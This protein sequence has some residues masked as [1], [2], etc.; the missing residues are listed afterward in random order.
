MMPMGNVDIERALESLF[1]VADTPGF[2]KRFP[3][4]Q[5]LKTPV[6]IESAR[7]VLPDELRPFMR[8]DQLSPPDVYAFDLGDPLKGKIVVWNGHAVVADWESMDGFLEWAL[9]GRPWR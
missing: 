4:A 6:E 9:S 8:E 5:L 3:K 7:E 2:R 1:A